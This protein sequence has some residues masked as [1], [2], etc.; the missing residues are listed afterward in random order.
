MDSEA[1][2][3]WLFC[4]NDV[5]A[6]LLRYAARHE[7]SPQAVF[8]ATWVLHQPGNGD[9]HADHFHVRVGCGPAERALGCR[10]Q[11]P[12]WPWHGDSASK[13]EHQARAQAN[14]PQLLGWLFAEEH[15]D[16]G[17]HVSGGGLGVAL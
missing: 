8:R 11:A 14:D 12:F 4:S 7:S 1:R 9:P 15:S 2:I 10:E 3:K 6:R 5:K 17:P 16:Q 13:E